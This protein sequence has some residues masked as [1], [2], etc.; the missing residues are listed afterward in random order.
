MIGV[1]N[2]IPIM[3]STFRRMIGSAEGGE[4]C[5]SHSLQYIQ[6]F[7]NISVLL[8]VVI[9]RQVA[10]ILRAHKRLDSNCVS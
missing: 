1:Y 10:S 3:I 9:N 5:I 2:I 4:S 8:C 6:A 7:F